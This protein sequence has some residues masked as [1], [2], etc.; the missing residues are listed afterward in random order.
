[1]FDRNGQSYYQQGYRAAQAHQQSQEVEAMVVKKGQQMP[2]LGT[3]KLH[4]LL[5]A[6][7][8]GGPL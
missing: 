6:D 3:G 4:E 7:R 8:S 5:K 2:R 1:L